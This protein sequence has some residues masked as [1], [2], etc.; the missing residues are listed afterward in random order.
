[1]GGVVARSVYYLFPARAEAPKVGQHVRVEGQPGEYVVLH[2]DSKRFAAD[3]MLTTGKHNV[4]E[5]VPYTVIEQL[6][7]QA[8]KRGVKPGREAA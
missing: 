6:N 7:E 2:L 4:E 8:M 3:L 1:M 5:N